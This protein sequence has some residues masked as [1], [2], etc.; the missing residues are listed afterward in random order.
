MPRAPHRRVHATHQRGTGDNQVQVLVLRDRHG[1]TTDFKLTAA[2]QAEEAPIIT[3]VV[4][5][6][7]VLCTD[8][9]A[10]LKGAA[11]QAGIAHRALNQSASVHVLAGV[12]HIQNVNAYD[13]GLKT[14]M[15]RFYGVATKYLQNYLGWRRGLERWGSQISPQLILQAAMGRSGAFQLLTHIALS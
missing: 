4:A 7:A 2:T 6:D 9:G 10:S 14:W 3:Q 15:G 11:R 12:Y 1:A 8:G 5:S 13:S